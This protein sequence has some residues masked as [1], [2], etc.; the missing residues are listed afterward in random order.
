MES[1]THLYIVLRWSSRWLG[2]ATAAREAWLVSY[3]YLLLLQVETHHRVRVIGTSPLD[4]WPELISF[5]PAGRI[6]RQLCTACVERFSN[7]GTCSNLWGARW[8]RTCLPFGSGAQRQSWVNCR[9]ASEAQ[10][11]F[12][13]TGARAARLRIHKVR[14][15]YYCVKWESSQHTL[16]RQQQLQEPLHTCYF[17]S[18]TLRTLSIRVTALLISALNSYNYCIV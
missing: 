17:Y 14:L 5:H 11:H 15:L 1:C 8:S 12:S 7:S 2:T 10:H 13:T 4:P 16:L 18:T 3:N 6:C 9:R